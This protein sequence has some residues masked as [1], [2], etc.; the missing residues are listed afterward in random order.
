MTAQDLYSLDWAELLE[1]VLEIVLAA[2]LATQGR[3]MNGVAW[4][5]DCDGFLRSEAIKSRVEV[6]DL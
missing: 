4:R 5:V 1:E 6:C 2:G 3:D